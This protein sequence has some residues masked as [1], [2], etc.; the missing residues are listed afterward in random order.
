MIE[1][2]RFF[3]ECHALS[4]P[5]AWFFAD[6]SFQPARVSFRRGAGMGLGLAEFPPRGLESWEFG[7]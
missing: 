4:S 3:C 7:V 1:G 2:E 5:L 6:L